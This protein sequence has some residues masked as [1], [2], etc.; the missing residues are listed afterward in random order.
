MAISG[1]VGRFDGVVESVQLVALPLLDDGEFLALLDVERVVKTQLVLPRAVGD[2]PADADA[3][4]EAMELHVLHFQ[5]DVHV[6]AFAA[7][8]PHLVVGALDAAGRITR[9]FVARFEEIRQVPE[10]VQA[11]GNERDSLAVPVE[12]RS[13]VY[14]HGWSCGFRR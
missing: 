14:L 11:L 4:G 2:D 7:R 10:V 8:V 5:R 9:D 3:V 13:V 6:F 12:G 1:I